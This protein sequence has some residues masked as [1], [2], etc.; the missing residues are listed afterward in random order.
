MRDPPQ[1]TVRSLPTRAPWRPQRHDRPRAPGDL[2]PGSRLARRGFRSLTHPRSVCFLWL[3]GC[4]HTLGMERRGSPS[5]SWSGRHGTVHP[6]LE[7]HACAWCATS[8]IIFAGELDCWA[9]TAFAAAG[10]SER[11]HESA[12][13]EPG[14]AASGRTRE[15]GGRAS[16][17]CRRS[18]PHESD[19]TDTIHPLGGRYFIYRPPRLPSGSG[20]P[21]HHRP[22]RDR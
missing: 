9:H 4:A 15:E 12:I 11:Q 1:L 14:G 10:V 21:R 20:V 2:D 13:V 18:R 17:A 22:R 3:L 19:P 6:R 8:P 16:L 7:N 5:A